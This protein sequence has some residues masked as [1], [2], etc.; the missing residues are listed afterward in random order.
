MPIA[1]QIQ[2]SRL[3]SALGMREV[4]FAMGADCPKIWALTIALKRRKQSLFPVFTQFFD[5]GRTLGGDSALPDQTL[6]TQDVA[7]TS[8]R[9]SARLL[10]GD[11]NRRPL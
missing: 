10:N 11:R 4:P 2:F 7:A 3:K 8:C 9:E 5:L 6:P 1:N